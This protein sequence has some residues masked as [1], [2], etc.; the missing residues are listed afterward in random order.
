MAILENALENSSRLL[1][2]YSDERKGFVV[3]RDELE[4][5]MG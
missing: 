1:H 3:W 2:D 5:M 4:A